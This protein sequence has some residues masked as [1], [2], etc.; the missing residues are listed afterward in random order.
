M[1]FLCLIILESSDSDPTQAGTIASGA[2]CGDAGLDTGTGNV[3]SVRDGR[4]L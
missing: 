1:E 4:D 3:M 2:V